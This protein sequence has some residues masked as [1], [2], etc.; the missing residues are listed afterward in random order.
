MSQNF[1]KKIK[2]WK[3][4]KH[5][6]SNCDKL[7]NSNFDKNQKLKLWQKSNTQIVTN[8]KKNQIV[9]KPKNSNCEKTEKLK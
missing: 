8:L 4:T 3:L 9:T 2:L 5:K 7:E 6:N 1:K